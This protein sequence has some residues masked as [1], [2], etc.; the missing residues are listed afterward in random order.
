MLRKKIAYLRAG[1][2]F[3]V[4]AACA[5]PENVSGAMMIP[6][7][8]DAGKV[9]DNV[10]KDNTTVFI[11]TPGNHVRFVSSKAEIEAGKKVF[12]DQRC[13]Q[14]HPIQ[15]AGGSVGPDLSKIGETRDALWLKLFL[16]NPKAELSFTMM[17]PFKGSSEELD[18]LVEYLSSLKGKD[19]GD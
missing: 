7:L 3:L 17:P 6:V 12:N 2:V 13:F 15:G 11:G 18:V 9:M 10:G 5:L 19:E 4:I 14:C 8:N 16:P 1:F